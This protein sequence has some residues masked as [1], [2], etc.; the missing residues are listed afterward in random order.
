MSVAAG[1]ATSDP[2]EL[3]AV[4]TTLFFNVDPGSG[5]RQLWK[6][7]G[8]LG[9][10]VLVSDNGGAGFHSFDERI[11]PMKQRAEGCP[12]SGGTLMNAIVLI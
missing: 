6:T 4:G 8:T 9:G 12:E 7:D 2:K 11:F 10:T 5:R 3:T 1:P